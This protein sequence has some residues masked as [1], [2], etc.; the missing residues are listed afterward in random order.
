MPTTY[1]LITS[2]T[3]DFAPMTGTAL[4]FAGTGTGT[5]PAKLAAPQGLEY[6]TVTT[7]S[8]GWQWAP[9]ANASG[10]QLQRAPVATNGTIGTYATVYTGTATSYT[11]TGLAA[12][13]T[14]AYRV[15]ANGT[16]AYSNS[17]YS[18][19]VQASTQAAGG[20]TPKGYQ[21]TY[22]TNYPPA[23]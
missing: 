21:A 3:Y 10:Y 4:V 23:G 16:G 7:T 20:T 5:T 22:A 12:G 15:R 9:V 11:N 2:D 8:L 6:T 17:D 1:T 14:Y 19:A 13:T 18:V